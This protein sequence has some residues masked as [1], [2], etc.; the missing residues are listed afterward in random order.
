MNKAYVNL[1]MSLNPTIPE[2][3]RKQLESEPI[4]IKLVSPAGGRELCGVIGNEANEALRPLTEVN[5]SWG[6]PSDE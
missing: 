2:E 6:E 4:E 3:A 1:M 5:C